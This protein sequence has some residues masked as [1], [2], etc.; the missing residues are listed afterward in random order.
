MAYSY[1]IEDKQVLLVAR[2][3]E[4]MNEI[5]ESFKTWGFNLLVEPNEERALKFLKVSKKSKAP[6]DVLVW[7]TTDGTLTPLEVADALKKLHEELIKVSVLIAEG[8][9]YEVREEIFNSGITFCLEKPVSPPELLDSSLDILG[10]EGYGHTKTANAEP[11]ATKSQHTKRILL[12]EDHYVN[13]R[14]VKSMLAEV[15]W[16]VEFANNGK[17]ALVL[18]QFGDYDAIL[19]DVG[20]PDL[21]GVEVT[22]RIR[23][24][25]KKHGGNIPII[26]LTAH[27]LPGDRERFLEA[28]MDD[29]VSKPFTFERLVETLKKAMRS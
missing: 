23:E 20:I 19:M 6:V 26:A 18:W 29:Y 10:F 12:A 3:S 25:E 22:R 7:D 5:A 17:N 4:E 8:E 2:E 21:N 28:G 15:G 27:A 1:K 9:T 13:Q 14:I 16:E 11:P 24:H